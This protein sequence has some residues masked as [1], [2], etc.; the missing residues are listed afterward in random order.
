MYKKE[1]HGIWKHL[2]FFILDLLCLQAALFI[3]YGMTHHE[4]HLYATAMYRYLAVGLTLVDMLILIFNSTLKNVLKRGMYVEFRETLKHT[5]Y[6]LAFGAIGMMGLKIGAS[7]SRKMFFGAFGIY[8]L[9]TYLVRCIW[10]RHFSNKSDEDGERSLLLIA[11][12]KH[13]KEAIESL[14]EQN[15]GRFRFAGLVVLD[16]DMTGK[17]ISGIEVVSNVEEAANYV[18]QEWIDEVLMIPGE[19]TEATET[20]VEQLLETGVTLH[21]NLAKITSEP[22]KKQTIEK[23]G[24]YT[25]LTTS[26]NTATTRQ[27]FVK[28]MVDILGGLAGCIL[29]GI[30]CIFVA[31]AIYIASPG[32]VFFS[33]ERVGKNGKVFK[34]YKFRSMYL[35]AEERKAALME[36]N[37]VS[38]AKMF[39]M[40][41]DP[42]VIGNRILPDGRKKTGI[43]QFIRNTSIDEFPQFFNVLKGDMSIVGTRPPLISE[44]SLY[45]LHHRTRLAIKP[46][47]TGMWQ[48]SGRSDITEF[49]EVVKLDQE[50]IN[51]WNLG[52]D[53]KILL[54]TVL[55]VFRKDGSV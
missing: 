37:K 48:V 50:Y 13:M 16:R 51:N 4:G 9:L 14:H 31:P 18:C 8:F 43:G 53:I 40:D 45:E 30:L 35:D 49:E 23:I 33:Q 44:V 7:Y 10:K 55:V 19:Q 54:K 11:D 28:R 15:F 38:D 47:I 29:T 20:L 39:K 41:F 5:A 27:L 52:M 6:L 1:T 25:V 21:M 32:P 42:R 3:S 36:Q 12:K 22:G 2:D 26:M 17:K 34:M 24:Q 46:G